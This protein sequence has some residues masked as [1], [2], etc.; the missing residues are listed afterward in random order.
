MNPEPIHYNS[1]GTDII[2]IADTPGVLE[3]TRHLLDEEGIPSTIERLHDTQSRSWGL[4][5]SSAAQDD[6]ERVLAN[7]RAAGS[8]VDWDQIDVGE[9]SSETQTD[10]RLK[11]QV[12]FI[13]TI[14]RWLGPAAV[15]VILFLSALGI[16][17]SLIG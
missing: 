4:V 6:A 9:P 5:V 17:L 15:I 11:G 2:E 14:I 1:L 12:R 16:I 8:L 13:S 7:K 10:L 3:V